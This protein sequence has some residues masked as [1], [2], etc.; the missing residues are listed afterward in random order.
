MK[1]RDILDAW[2]VGREISFINVQQ[3]ICQFF[4]IEKIKILLRIK[5]IVVVK[6]REVQIWSKFKGEE[7][8]VLVLK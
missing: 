2:W 5:G 3:I 1:I 8:Y 7:N 6:V 4:W